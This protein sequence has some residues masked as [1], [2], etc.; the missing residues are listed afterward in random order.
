MIIFIKKLHIQGEADGGL[1]GVRK[2]NRYIKRVSKN[3]E[4]NW[5]KLFSGLAIHFKTTMKSTS[6]SQC[7]H[8][9][10]NDWFVS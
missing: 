8:F 1:S 5:D 7:E 9:R 4:E 10:V 6:T 3:E 2:Q